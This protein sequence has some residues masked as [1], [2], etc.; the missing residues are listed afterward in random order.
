MVSVGL[1][2]GL[3]EEAPKGRNPHPARRVA[4][5]ASIPPCHARITGSSYVA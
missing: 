4:E 5:T 2:D 1:G 3:V